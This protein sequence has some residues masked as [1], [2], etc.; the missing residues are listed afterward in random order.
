MTDSG[1]YVNGKRFASKSDYEAALDDKKLID[2]IRSKYDFNNAE[3]I[4]TLYRDLSASKFKFRSSLGTDFDDEVFELTRQIKAGTFVS[5]DDEDEAE[6][7]SSVFKR[8]KKEPKKKPV[9]SKPVDSKK[10]S[11]RKTG[12]SK[13]K[14]LDLD[15]MSPSMREQVIAEI[16]KSERKRKLFLFILAG[17]CVASLG[18]YCV[19]YFYI[20]RT[21]RTYDQWA[22]IREADDA[23]VTPE[24]RIKQK[25]INYTDPTVVPDILEKYKTLYNKNKSLIGW[26]KIADTNIDYP[27][28]Q[29]S[30][31]EYYLDHNLNQE[32][33]KNG[34]IFLDMGCDVLKPSTNLIC[35]GHHMQSGKMFGK[36]G[37]Y[38]KESYYENHKFIEFDTIYEEGL[39]QVMYVFRSH[40]YTSGEIAFKYYQFIDATSEEEFN[41]YMTEM[42]NMSYYDTGVTATYGDRLL[43]L[44]TCDYQE[45]DGRFVV[46]AKKIQ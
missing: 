42:S 13:K 12:L 3:S 2:E 14:S 44:S 43:T 20:E 41:S 5:N 11:T 29:T 38:E 18:Y 24:Q 31:N 23:N 4:M 28:M 26:I 45:K 30:N 19:Y 40:V 46:V 34:S 39:Y 37:E 9:K 17:V 1:F 10:D 6:E 27:V 36:L 22:E 8:I 21:E 15:S 35:Y 7:K 32:Y 25:Q 16:K 33:D